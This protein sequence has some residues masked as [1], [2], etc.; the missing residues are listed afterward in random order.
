MPHQFSGTLTEFA[1]RRLPR[2]C[3]RASTTSAGSFFLAPSWWSAD[4]TDPEFLLPS[5]TLLTIVRRSLD[6]LVL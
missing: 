1:L 2:L 3:C 4:L 5:R 6:D